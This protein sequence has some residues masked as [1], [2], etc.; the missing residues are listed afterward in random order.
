M[1]NQEMIA[2]S[3]AVVISKLTCENELLRG[4]KREQELTE[5]IT[6]EVEKYRWLIER[7]RLLPAF[8]GPKSKYV[9]KASYVADFCLLLTKKESEN[10]ELLEEIRKMHEMLEPL[11]KELADIKGVHSPI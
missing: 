5:I 3:K 9:Q 8:E 10:E 11:I 1:T 6:A 7:W 2:L 4:G